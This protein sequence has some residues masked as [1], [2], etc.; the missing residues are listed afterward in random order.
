MLF[1]VPLLNTRVLPHFDHRR[2]RHPVVPIVNKEKACA[3]VFALNMRPTHREDWNNYIKTPLSFARKMKSR[4]IN[5]NPGLVIKYFN[6]IE[7]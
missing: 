6:G 4:F 2:F 1:V 7:E 3:S 5:L